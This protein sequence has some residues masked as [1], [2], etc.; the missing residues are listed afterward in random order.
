MKWKHKNRRRVFKICFGCYSV[1]C[2]RSRSI[3]SWDRLEIFLD[4]IRFCRS[5][6]FTVCL[7]YDP[8][9]RFFQISAKSRPCI[10]VMTSIR[11]G[12]YPSWMMFP[13]VAKSLGDSFNEPKPNSRRACNRFSAFS[14]LVSIRMSMSFVYRGSRWKARANAPMMQY[15][16]LYLFNSAK[17]SS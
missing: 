9:M 16:T 10:D 13:G 7:P 12:S 11:T 3:L 14:T 6:K 8:W 2:N 4:L 15:F 1:P 5:M 17:N